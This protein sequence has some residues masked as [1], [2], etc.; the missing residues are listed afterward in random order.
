[1]PLDRSRSSWCGQDGGGDAGRD[2]EGCVEVGVVVEA[3]E[4]VG[5]VGG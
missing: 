3:R 4:R 5:E 2:E 1:M